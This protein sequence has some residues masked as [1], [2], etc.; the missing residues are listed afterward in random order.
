M[1][2]VKTLAEENESPDDSGDSVEPA[3]LDASEEIEAKVVQWSY[4]ELSRYQLTG[5]KPIR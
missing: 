1:P 4:A 3:V 2:K 5:E